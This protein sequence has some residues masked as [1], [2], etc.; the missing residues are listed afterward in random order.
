M[1]TYGVLLA[2]TTT[3]RQKVNIVELNSK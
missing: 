3:R 1:F 2:G